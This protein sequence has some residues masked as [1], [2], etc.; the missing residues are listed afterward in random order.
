MFFFHTCNYPS[1]NEIWV[2]DETTAEPIV[3]EILTARYDFTLLKLLRAWHA[4][5]TPESH[6]SYTPSFRKSIY[7]WL[8]VANRYQLPWDILF[9]IAQFLPR[10]YDQQSLECW[11]EDC[12]VDSAVAK[13]RAKLS[14]TSCHIS[15]NGVLSRRRLIMDSPNHHNNSHNNHSHSK[16]IPHCLSQM[17][18]GLLQI[19]GTSKKGIVV[20]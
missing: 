2:A 3:D 6:H 7:T 16:K 1:R 9:S 14:D 20:P 15:A 10:T 18:G 11:C 4:P 19:R 5:W 17:H 12:I 13:M 8:L